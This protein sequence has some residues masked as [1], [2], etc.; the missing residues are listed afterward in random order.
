M[1]TLVALVGIGTIGF[2]ASLIFGGTALLVA[3]MAQVV[4]LVAIALHRTK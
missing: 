2:G 4:V 3:V 1:K